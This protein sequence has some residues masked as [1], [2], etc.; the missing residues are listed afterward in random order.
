LDINKK[1]AASFKQQL[2]QAIQYQF[3]EATAKAEEKK[4]NPNK[5]CTFKNIRLS[6]KHN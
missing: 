3:A 1:L 2:Q 5:I 6:E 4:E